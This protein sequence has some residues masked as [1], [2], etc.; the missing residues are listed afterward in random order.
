MIKLGSGKGSS[1]AISTVAPAG[2]AVCVVTGLLLRKWWRSRREPPRLTM[3]LP[4]L[5][6]IMQF[7]KDPIEL[8]R[9][10]QNKIGGCFSVN[11]LAMDMVFLV[12]P[13]GQEFF[14]T[15]DKYLDQAKMYKFTVPIFGPKVLYDTDLSTRTSQLRFIRERLTD[16][17]LRSYTSSLEAE[18]QLF[19]EEC[20]TGDE[21]VV[22][23]VESMQECLTRT[24]VR[25]LMGRELRSKLHVV[26]EGYSIV[27]LLHILEQGMLPLSVFMPNAPIPRH[28]KRDEARRLIREMIAPVLAERRKAADK[29][30]TDFLQSVMNS[31]YP[32]GRA[33]TDEEI[34]G[35]LVAAFFGGMHNSSITS[36]W[37]TLEIFSRPEL[38][39]DLL[40]EQQVALGAPD[41]PFTFQG[42]Q[43][44]K[45]LR[46][47]VTE[48]LRMH[49]P[50]MLLMRTVEED[51]MFQKH[52]IRRGNV[53][54]VSPNVGNMLEEAFPNASTFDPKRFIDGVPD[55]WAYIPF[56]GGRR[57]CKGQEFGFM[58]IMCVLSSM[59]RLFEITCLDGVTKATVAK[60]GLVIAPSQPCR[61]QYR[62]RVKS[63]VSGK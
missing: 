33:I 2:A 42:Y 11:F 50:L 56:G 40:E 38:A 14:F 34:V 47:V 8:V 48:T 46:A 39:K 57:I 1:S 45:K 9:K 13:E 52:L 44:M 51:V 61:V 7:L 16:N 20:W 49:P 22:N 59:L 17:F 12:G 58:Q 41:A 36:S 5:G 25:C 30:E 37:S 53:V 43:A 55:Q 31:H 35:F 32:D 63:G 54:A 24:S 21:G 27:Q 18:V 28:R 3:G 60:D 10:G 15:N 6:P 62:R 19:F 23:I 26:K 4:I 29:T